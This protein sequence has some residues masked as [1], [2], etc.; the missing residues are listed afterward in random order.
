VYDEE[1]LGNVIPCFRRAGVVVN[2][3]TWVIGLGR[4][5]RQIRVECTNSGA[6]PAIVK[7]DICDDAARVDNARQNPYCSITDYLK[8]IDE[9]PKERLQGMCFGPSIFLT[10]AQIIGRAQRVDHLGL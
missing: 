7:R 10:L 9:A 2:L 6:M 3:R 4:R 5:R 8:T 1:E